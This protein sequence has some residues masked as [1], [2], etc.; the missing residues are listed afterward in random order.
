MDE[1][2]IHLG[3]ESF[4]QYFWLGNWLKNLKR[5]KFYN[6]DHP[7]KHANV[8]NKTCKLDNF[9]NPVP[10]LE[11]IN[12]LLQKLREF[13]FSCDQHI[14]SIPKK[15]LTLSDDKTQCQKN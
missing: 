8:S 4:D 7:N 12:I 1:N 6:C 13:P 10:S 5:V 3:N 9:V 15:T 2:Q 14:I 11:S